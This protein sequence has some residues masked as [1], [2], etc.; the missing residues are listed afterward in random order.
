MTLLG[1]AAHPMYQYA[2]Q[3]ACQA[4]EDA[5]VLAEYMTQHED[6][7][8]AFAAY[9]SERTLRT[10]RIQRT[11]RWFGDA[12]HLGGPGALIRNQI[13]SRRDPADYAQFDYLYGYGT[14]RAVM[15][16][17]IDDVV[18]SSSRQGLCSDD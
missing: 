8:L 14:D 1:D 12:I 4:I 7:R 5:W 18:G 3:G 11:A 2:A 6:V 17:T 13:L 15:A 9:E 10:A 16:K